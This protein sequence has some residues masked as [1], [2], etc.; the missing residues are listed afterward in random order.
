MLHEFS[1]RLRLN[2]CVAAFGDMGTEHEGKRSDA[3][4]LSSEIYK[5]NFVANFSEKMS[6]KMLVNGRYLLTL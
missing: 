5:D 3:F 2:H 4:L 6:M 1:S